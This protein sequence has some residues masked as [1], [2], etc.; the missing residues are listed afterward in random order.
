MVSWEI[1]E[2]NGIRK[3]HRIKTPPKDDNKE[4]EMMRGYPLSLAF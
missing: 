1:E 2:Q 4:G 3:C